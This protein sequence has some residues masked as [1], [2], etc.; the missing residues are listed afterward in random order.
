[1]RSLRSIYSATVACRALLLYAMTAALT[2]GR[3][4]AAEESPTKPLAASA[5]LFR[6]QLDTIT[7]GYDGCY[8]WAQARAGAI[9]RAGQPPIVVVT[10]SPLLVTGSDVYFD[11]HE[12][13][14]DDL[15][16]S[17]SGPVRH[18]DTLGRHV[19][20]KV[21]G[22]DVEEVPGDFWPQW[23]A[24]SG[25]LLGIG[26]TFQYVDDKG[27]IKN[28]Q[29]DTC[30][31]VYDPER[32]TWS[33]LALLE[34]PAGD[35]RYDVRAACV[36]RYDLP[37]GDILLPV[38]FKEEQDK[39]HHVKVLRCRF[40]G[41]KLMVQ[42]EGNTLSL[43]TQRGLAEPS[44]TQCGGKFFLT[45]RHDTAAYVTTSNDGLHFGEMK[46]WTWDDGSDLGSYNTQAHWVVHRDTLFLVYTRRGA[47]NDHVF[48]HRAPLFMAEIDVEK[49]AVKRASE[50][51]L[52][53]EH[54]ARYGNFG[55]CDVN[56]QET[57]VIETE[58]MQRP[59]EEPFIPVKNRWGANARI[60]AA[61]IIWE[62]PA[63]HDN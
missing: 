20:G 40:D 13:R 59:P 63:Q 10:A 11:L 29:A 32:R 28:R 36:Q 8:C 7:E 50:R 45:I 15:G 17:W 12:F 31:T 54:G 30:Y 42:G 62:K 33:P 16:K 53:P 2:A 24:A 39:F 34:M 9:P 46:K 56:E 51:V 47:N 57:W 35:V 52:I 41:T 27:P 44:I 60:Y 61:R 25:K 43:D 38:Y 49:L 19:I 58:W 6:I 37:N 22:K 23:H 21:G 18:H 4:I 3:P 48:R 1:M 14:T 5:A 55:V 26:V